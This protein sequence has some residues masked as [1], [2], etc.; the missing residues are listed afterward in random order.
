[1]TFTTASE[2]FAPK[3]FQLHEALGGWGDGRSPQAALARG[4]YLVERAAVVPGPPLEQS[5]LFS[6]PP[7]RAEG[8]NILTC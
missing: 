6:R 1:M 8:S 2:M 4:H 3:A 5:V 7:Q